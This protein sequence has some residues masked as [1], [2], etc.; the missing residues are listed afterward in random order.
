MEF[1]QT[2]KG[3]AE[4]GSQEKYTHRHAHACTHTHPHVLY[5]VVLSGAGKNIITSV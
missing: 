4:S 5:G 3:K 1:L 2:K